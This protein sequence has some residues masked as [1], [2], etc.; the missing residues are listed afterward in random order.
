MCRYSIPTFHAIQPKNITTKC[1]FNF[2]LIILIWQ[3]YTGPFAISECKNTSLRSM[4]H[5]VIRFRRYIFQRCNVE[6]FVSIRVFIS[7]C[8]LINFAHFQQQFYKGVCTLLQSFARHLFA[9][10]YL[11]PIHS[12]STSSS[13]PLCLCVNVVMNA[14]VSKIP[15]TFEISIQNILCAKYNENM[16][17]SNPFKDCN[18]NI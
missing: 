1:K 11:L 18:Q 3:Y 6:R 2:A 16:K 14:I 8:H 17:N 7:V 10:L 12:H 9:F 15:F 4:L 5:C 13:C